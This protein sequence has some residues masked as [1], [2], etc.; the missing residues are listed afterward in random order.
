MD[1]L[2]SQNNIWI[3]LIALISGAMLLWPSLTKGRPAGR[4]NLQDAIRQINQEHGLFV[5]IRPADQYRSGSIPQAKNIPLDTLDA[6]SGNL[7]KN[8]PIVL[9]DDRG[10]QASRAVAVLRKQGFERVASLD[11]GLHAWMEGGMPLKKF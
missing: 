9:F 11:G 5:D 7:P 2:L 1:F 10:R 4:V 6:Q 8:K 3:V